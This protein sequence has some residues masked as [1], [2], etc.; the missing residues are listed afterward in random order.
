MIA[1]LLMA[2]VVPSGCS[3]GDSGGQPTVAT[4]PL[5]SAP[6]TST[7]QPTG[8][9]GEISA[10]GVGERFREVVNDRNMEAVAGLAPTSSTEIREFLLGGGPYETVDCY[11]FAGRDECHVVNGIADFVFVIDV[12]RGL[13]TEITYVGGA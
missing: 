10:L 11:E 4:T 7:S 5:T 12:A 9:P 1:V 13:V 6:P 8:S 3:L 2:I